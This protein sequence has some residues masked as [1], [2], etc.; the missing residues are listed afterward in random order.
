MYQQPSKNRHVSNTLFLVSGH[1]YYPCE[2]GTCVETNTCDC[3]PGWEGQQCQYDIDECWYGHHVCHHN[4]RNHEGCYT[5]FCDDGFQLINSTHCVASNGTTTVEPPLMT[6]VSD[7]LCVTTTAATVGTT[8]ANPQQTTTRTTTSGIRNTA[9]TTAADVTTARRPQRD[10]S[11]TAPQTSSTARTTE[12][13]V[14]T[15]R[16]SQDVT[17]GRQQR[18][19]RTT[20][21]GL[22]ISSTATA[23]RVALTSARRTQRTTRATA[24]SLHT[25][26]I[27]TTTTTARITTAKRPLRTITTEAPGRHMTLS[28]TGPIVQ[29]NPKSPAPRGRT[30]QRNVDQAIG[31]AVGAFALALLMI[32]LGIIFCKRR[33]KAAA[34]QE[35]LF[36][37][38]PQQPRGSLPGY[39]DTHWRNPAFENLYEEIPEARSPPPPYEATEGCGATGGF[40]DVAAMSKSGITDRN[41]VDMFLAGTIPAI[42]SKA[43]KEMSPPLCNLHVNIQKEPLAD[44]HGYEPLK[45]V[46]GNEYESLKRW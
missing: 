34:R 31:G 43:L 37:N 41:N 8:T 46:P 38:L 40:A 33:K 21:R 27:A 3:D 29:D 12:A 39:S 30:D 5:C 16:R 9:P 13:D 20:S 23:T 6:T 26:F 45:K 10:T 17:T 7:S 18:A 28:V 36:S 35:R 15:A 32:S 19:T 42:P 25:S 22:H 1:C 2:H 14:T 11:T 4:C 24:S 44:D